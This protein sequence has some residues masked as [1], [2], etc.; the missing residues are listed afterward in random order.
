MIFG[1]THRL[2]TLSNLFY[3]W[4]YLSACLLPIYL[5]VSYYHFDIID[6]FYFGSFVISFSTLTLALTAF[7]KDHKIALE[8][9]GMLFSLSAFLPFLYDPDADQ[10]RP[11]DY[12]AMIVPNSAFTIAL[13]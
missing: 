1:L 3:M 8:L 4:I 5:T 9:I 13:L 7:F 11:I 6:V 2:H 12:L 10:Y